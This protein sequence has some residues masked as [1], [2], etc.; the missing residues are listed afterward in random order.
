MPRLLLIAALLIV[1]ASAAPAAAQVGE[2]GAVERI[3]AAVKRNGFRRVGVLPR[4]IVREGGREVL[5]GA[6][7]PQAD[8]MAEGLEEQLIFHAEDPAAG[9]KV[10]DG[11]RMRA[12]FAGLTIDD[13]GRPDKLR[14]VAEAVG[15]L[16]GLVVGTITDQRGQ[17]GAGGDLAIRCRLIGVRDGAVA[18]SATE[19]AS[20]SVE[21]GAYAGESWELRRWVGSR[22]TNVG[23]A[24]KSPLTQQ[25]VSPFGFE[26][27][28]S[29]LHYRMIR[30]DRPHPLNDSTFP[31]PLRVSVDGE[32]RRLHPVGNKVYTVLDP[33]ETYKIHLGAAGQKDVYASL[34][35]DGIN[36]LGKQREH[37]AKSRYWYIQPGKTHAFSGWTLPTAKP[38]EY[39]TEEFTIT[40]ADDS[41]AAGQGFGDRLGLI[42][43]V[44]YNVGVEGV[45]KAP[46][47][48]AA[49]N[50]GSFGTG[51]GR[52]SDVTL[53]EQSGPP[54]GPLLSAVTIHYV[55][56]SELERIK[57]GGT[58]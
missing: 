12:A 39:T 2:E 58:Q 22:L 10:V 42:T 47:M 3:V 51:A 4:L 35:V 13:L 8:H 27:M 52:Q 7:G 25:D 26:G 5:G 37:P 48:Y 46:G 19:N 55:T 56:S 45:P 20:L 36:V 14:Q 40:L 33:G 53:Q 57:A 28:Y 24:A 23:L 6:I 32:Q 50:P 17:R 54:A 9:F 34:F 16:D 38:G 11:R 49:M 31:Y 30:R 15:G 1:A 43:C 41:V 21:D 44:I 29:L 18:T